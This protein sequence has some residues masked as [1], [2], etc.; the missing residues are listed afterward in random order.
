MYALI[1][2]LENIVQDRSLLIKSGTI[3]YTIRDKNNK[4]NKNITTVVS[5][6]KL[7]ATIT[8]RKLL[9]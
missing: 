1:K 4:N 8:T 7:T 2:K 9:V 5:W 3:K 6:A